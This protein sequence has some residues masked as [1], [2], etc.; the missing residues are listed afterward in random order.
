MRT[1]S[2]E[3][4]RGHIGEPETQPEEKQIVFTF[5]GG[6]VEALEQGSQSLSRAVASPIEV[7]RRKGSSLSVCPTKV[8]ALPQF[9]GL[10]HGR[11]AGLT[12]RAA[13]RW[14]RRPVLACS[15]DRFWDAPSRKKPGRSVKLQF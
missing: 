10:G 8:R 5:Q 7:Q 14:L 6:V 1:R 3:C 9:Q 2:E 11:H 4:G 13:E 12:W 15:C